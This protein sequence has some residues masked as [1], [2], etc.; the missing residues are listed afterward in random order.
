MSMLPHYKQHHLAAD[1]EKIMVV[2]LLSGFYGL[3]QQRLGKE[4]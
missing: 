4:D 3:K 1:A 2:Q